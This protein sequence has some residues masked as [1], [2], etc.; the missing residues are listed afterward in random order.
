MFLIF[1][2]LMKNE[3][4]ATAIE[5]AA[6][7]L[8]HC[9]RRHCRDEQRRRSGRRRGLVDAGGIFSGRPALTSLFWWAA[10]L[11]HFR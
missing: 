1:H 9:R 11:L 10:S 6:I 2:G 7:N 5:Y 3:H 4:G 8:A